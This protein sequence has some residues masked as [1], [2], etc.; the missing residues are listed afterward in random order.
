MWGYVRDAESRVDLER[1]QRR[2]GKVAEAAL[3]TLL[4]AGQL[5]WL[6]FN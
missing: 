5:G 4:L 3:Y 6:A 1:A 2:I